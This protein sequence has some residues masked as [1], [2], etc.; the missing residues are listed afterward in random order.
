MAFAFVAMGART[1]FANRAYGAAALAPA[2]VQGAISAAI[3]L[4]L[5]RVLEAMSLRLS[6]PTAYAL[7]PLVTASAIL[8]ILVTVHEIIGTPQVAA[9]IAVPW[10]VSS[11][12]A[13]VYAA[14]LA[15]RARG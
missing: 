8:A 1:L 10:S 11:L 15:R 12:Y 4:V 5:K 14:I 7:P 2:L 3:T 13:V 9:T 6:G